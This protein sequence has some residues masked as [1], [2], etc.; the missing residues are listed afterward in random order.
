MEIMDTLGFL[1]G[2]WQ[3]DRSI[4]DHQSGTQ[5]SFEGTATF[6]EAAF[7]S[8]THTEGRARYE[9]SGELHFGDHVGQT[10]RGL[11]YVR[12]D[13]A[14]VALLFTDGR[15]FVDLDLSAGAWQSTHL[16]GDDRYEI[17]THVRS[18][19][20]IEERWWVAGP[21]KDYEAVTILTRL[22]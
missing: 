21:T 5:G 16:C 9:E 14:T 11:D 18:A 1:L 17:T 4:E 10:H 22:E 15:P 6:T 13:T 12:S 2:T 3:V 19:D 20:L 7:G 8:D